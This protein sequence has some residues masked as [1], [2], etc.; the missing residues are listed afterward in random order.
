M[1]HG[2]RP[3]SPN[4]WSTVQRS[5]AWSRPDQ[6][7]LPGTGCSLLLA[8]LSSPGHIHPIVP[9]P[10][11]GGTGLHHSGAYLLNPCS[12]RCGNAVPYPQLPPGGAVAAPARTI[13]SRR[14]WLAL[15]A[16]PLLTP[17]PA[18]VAPAARIIAP[19]SAM[20]PWRLARLGTQ[21]GDATVQCTCSGRGLGPPQLSIRSSAAISSSRSAARLACPAH[22]GHH[23]V[24]ASREVLPAARA[25]STIRFTMAAGTVPGTASSATVT[26][27]SVFYPGGAVGGAAPKGRASSR[28]GHRRGNS[29]P[30][31][32]HVT[33]PPASV[34]GLLPPVFIA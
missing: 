21:H 3:R 28:R 25:A 2:Q 9:N 24:V 29:P 26:L 23:A 13:R 1:L 19:T 14:G 15:L 11:A 33:V 18:G 32:L 31:D 22:R 30:T 4:S 7:Q 6:I 20:L 16:P 10:R 34:P 5:L 27:T 12:Q 17:V 8:P